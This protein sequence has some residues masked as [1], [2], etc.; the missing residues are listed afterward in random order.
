MRGG[1]KQSP[2]RISRIDVLKQL[3]QKCARC[4][5]DDLQIM[6]ID[7]RFGNGHQENLILK[8]NSQAFFR[9]VLKHKRR[10][11]PLCPNCNW[12]KRILEDEHRRKNRN[13]Y[14]VERFTVLLTPPDGFRL[15]KICHQTDQRIPHFIRNVLVTAVA[16]AEQ[17]YYFRERRHSRLRR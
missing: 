4:G 5:L 7:H 2:Y 8:Q 16:K 1:V 14:L 15:K 9:H 11:Q 6:Q 12:R 13:E 10:Y 17:K 3:G